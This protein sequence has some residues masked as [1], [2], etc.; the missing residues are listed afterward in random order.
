MY[1][2]IVFFSLLS[3]LLIGCSGE[4]S[5]EMHSENDEVKIDSSSAEEII[6]ISN[7][8]SV[9]YIY[10]QRRVAF[11]EAN[12]K[13][14]KVE[15]N[16]SVEGNY[17]HTN[18][19]IV[20]YNFVEYW[21]VDYIKYAIVTKAVRMRND[22]IEE[23]MNDYGGLTDFLKQ[24][25]PENTAFYLGNFEKAPAYQL[26][27]YQSLLLTKD[28]NRNTHYESTS[29]FYFLHSELE[30]KPMFAQTMGEGGECE[31]FKGFKE[32]F[33]LGHDPYHVMIEREENIYDQECN[34]LQSLNYKKG[35]SEG[36]IL[37][38]KEGGPP[39]EVPEF[40]VMDFVNSTEFAEVP[41]SFFELVIEGADTLYNGSTFKI[42][43]SQYANQESAFTDEADYFVQDLFLII[44]FEKESEA[45]F[46]LYKREA[47]LNSDR[48]VTDLTALAESE[49]KMAFMELKIKLISEN[50]SVYL[51]TYPD[52][53]KE[54]L[55]T[56]QKE[57]FDT[58]EIETDL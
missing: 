51:F 13:E 16:V 35:Y 9:S 43:Q 29:Q 12:Y 22:L 52:S 42:V 37:F 28:N 23:D 26:V 31:K 32:R 57:V 40:F 4:D 24:S 18:G 55:F 39:P 1:K 33:V 47:G 19:G 49:K 45:S 34:L 3:F 11:L 10:K 56:T 30:P 17:F 8:D 41:K 44:G 48:Q 5:T 7:I 6:D 2:P 25:F 20:I 14:E 54:Y 46:T 50:K 36:H 53:G 21:G 27:D 15:Y 58:A 38:A